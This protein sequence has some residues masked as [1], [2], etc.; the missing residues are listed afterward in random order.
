MCYNKKVE[1]ILMD[2]YNTVPITH[3]HSLLGFITAKGA[4]YA[5]TELFTL[6]TCQP[7]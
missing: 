4:F 7:A 3:I 2:T 1:N 5:Y 6:Q